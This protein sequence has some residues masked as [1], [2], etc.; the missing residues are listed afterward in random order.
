MAVWLSLGGAKY[1]ATGRGF[2]VGHSNFVQLFRMFSNSH[3]NYGMGL[4]MHLVVYRFYI[5]DPNAYAGVSWAS[6]LFA[7]D[8]LY[9]P[10]I[11]NCKAF[12]HDCVRSDIEVWQQFM[13]RTDLSDPNKSWRAHFNDSNAMFVHSEYF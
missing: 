1:L 8:L 10:F 5:A 4:C 2:V 12:D 6:W 11:F 13:S 9:A 7:L 3:F